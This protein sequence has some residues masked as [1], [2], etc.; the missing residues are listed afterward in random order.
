M[1]VGSP[2]RRSDGSAEQIVESL[3]VSNHR[4]AVVEPKH[5]QNL[6]ESRGSQKM[7]LGPRLLAH[8]G[9]FEEHSDRHAGRDLDRGK[10]DQ[11]SPHGRS[12]GR[13]LTDETHD[14]GGTDGIDSGAS[15]PRQ[16][17]IGPEGEVD[18]GAWLVVVPVA[19]KRAGTLSEAGGKRG[20]SHVHTNPIR[21]TRRAVDA[22]IAPGAVVGWCGL[23][24]LCRLA[25][26][27]RTY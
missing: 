21:F 14:L 25:L 1:A 24:G 18:A 7:A 11:E 12:P 26:G 23:G 27:S 13:R 3:T 20:D 15:W 22:E 5:P 19:A 2:D 6:H 17:G 4:I 16:D 8:A 9:E 10:V